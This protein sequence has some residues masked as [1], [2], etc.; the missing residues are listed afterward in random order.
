MYVEATN[1]NVASQAEI[2]AT[3]TIPT[4]EPTESATLVVLNDYEELDVFPVQVVGNLSAI[5]TDT[6][7]IMD[8][9]LTVN[10]TAPS[11]TTG[12]LNLVFNGSNDSGPET[13]NAPFTALAPGSQELQLDFDSISPGI[14][15]MAKGTWNAMLP[16]TS[17]AQTVNV[18][19]YPLPT[20]WDYFRRVRFSRYNTPNEAA[21]ANPC[22][23]QP[24]NA[25]IVTSVTPIR[26][27]QGTTYQCK[28]QQITLNSQF[29]QQTWINGTG[30]SSNY[31]Y[32]KN[33]A[34]V[35][36]GDRGSSQKCVGEYPD[37]AIGHSGKNG[38]TFVVVYPPIT[39]S[40]DQP[41]VAG[42]SA[43]MPATTAL[44]H[45][46]PLSCGFQLNMDDRYHNSVGTRMIA[47]KCPA[48]DITTQNDGAD[49]HIDSFTSDDSCTGHN[50]IDVPGSPFYTSNI[51]NQ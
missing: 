10:L 48:C 36:E 25:W 35:K 4:S 30:L 32:L 13:S 33:A 12:D 26:S 6:S 23:G 5:I 38:N 31:G 7:D 3:I 11:G 2:T 22:T 8:G 18:P 44:S 46:M 45:V 51:T 9:N 15:P 47:D 42:V 21:V 43:A 29:I 24:A 19:D 34:A 16:G 40:C 28:F 20:E 14:Y 41:L 27:I 39:G 37:G 17:T 50:I 1:I 49:G